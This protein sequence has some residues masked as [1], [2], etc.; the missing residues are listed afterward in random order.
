MKLL[1]TIHRYPVAWFCALT[2]VLSFGTYLLPLPRTVLPFLIV[3]V[4]ALISV[5]LTGLIE[6]QTGI[7]RLLRKF[8]QWHVSVKWIAITL[9]LALALRL[10]MS[11]A[12]VA[13]GWITTIQI[14]SLS[15]AQVGLL[16][17][18]LLLSAIPEELGWRGFALPRLLKHQSPL[19]ASLLIGVVWG[20]L[21]LSL[22]L[23]GMMNEGTSA[24]PTIIEVTGLSIMGTW[25][26]MNT[27]GNLPILTLFHAAQSFFVIVNEGLSQAQQFWLMAGVYAVFAIV[28]VLIARQNFQPAVS[29][30]PSGSTEA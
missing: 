10:T 14:R 8:L 22:L 2:V 24:L 28:I 4:P 26:F 23:P 3:L 7:N 13:L 25:L 15:L 11:L 19:V 20:S 6:G 16:A 18:V 5:T 12:A 29:A 17:I 1:S 30:N 21:H 27:H 9:V